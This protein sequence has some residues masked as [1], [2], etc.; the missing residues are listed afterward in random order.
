VSAP[1]KMQPPAICRTWPEG[2]TL[3]FEEAHRHVANAYRI[4]AHDRALVE[5]TLSGLVQTGWLTCDPPK[6]RHFEAG[7]RFTLNGPPPEPQQLYEVREW[8]PAR[9]V[10]RTVE[11]D[12]V[13]IQA[14]SSLP[15]IDQVRTRTP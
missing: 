3:K 11:V 6:V 1:H 14:W 15:E 9:N 2:K 13:E 5:A 7:D 10:R 4:P 8:V 12:G